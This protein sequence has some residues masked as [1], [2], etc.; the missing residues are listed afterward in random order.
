MRS[1]Y[2][3]SSTASREPCHSVELVCNIRK[4][5]TESRSTIMAG[6]SVCSGALRVRIEPL[7]QRCVDV[8]DGSIAA[9]VEVVDGAFSAGHLA[10]ADAGATNGVFVMP[11]AE[12]HRMQP[13]RLRCDAL[14]SA[15]GNGI[16][17]VPRQCGVVELV[18]RVQKVRSG[19]IVGPRRRP[20]TPLHLAKLAAELGVGDC[21]M[22]EI[23]A[24]GQP[25]PRGEHQVDGRS[26]R[27]LIGA[28][29]RFVNVHDYGLFTVEGV[30]VVGAS[31]LG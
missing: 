3:S 2:C 6:V 5:S 7:Q 16:C 17:A 18:H 11:Q 10:V 1:S 19:R 25:G 12:V 14:V 23:V 28:Q 31:L 21:Q 20:A 27:P 26:R 30:E 13:Q 29:R 4:V 15:C 22:P 24:R 8:L 9:C